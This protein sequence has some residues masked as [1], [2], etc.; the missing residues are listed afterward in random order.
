VARVPLVSDE[1]GAADAII[2]RV[3]GRFGEEGRTPIALYRALANSPTLLQAYSGL[4][5]ALRYDAGTERALRELAILRTAHLIGS[6][7]E[8]AHHVVMA[9]AA[10]LPDS[11]IEAVG[12]W[13]ER[14]VFDAR[15]RAL[16]RA[17]DECHAV[18]LSD[19]AFAGLRD[20]FGVPEAVEL[21]MLLGFYQAVAR[22]I[23][24]L[25]IE[26]EPAYRDV[27][28]LPDQA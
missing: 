12:A 3:Y 24:G 22:M 5:T 1:D 27:T 2:A 16:L 21:V 20:A 25:G 4:A 6:A 26:L 17:A 11:K 7:Y 10:G 23:D 9:R 14:G 18:A 28:P 15:E 19:E 13:R 8:W